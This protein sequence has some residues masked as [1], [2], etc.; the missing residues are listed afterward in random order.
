MGDAGQRIVLHIFIAPLRPAGMPEAGEK[1]EVRPRRAGFHDVENFVGLAG[2]LGTWSCQ[3]LISGTAEELENPE[4]AQTLELLL[5]CS[6]KVEPGA[7][8]V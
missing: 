8:R 4:I 7:M 6:P 3:Q 1:L 5:V 2:V